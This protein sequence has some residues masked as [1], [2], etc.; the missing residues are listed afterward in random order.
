MGCSRPPPRNE[1][2][3][4]RLTFCFFAEDT[5]I[6]S[7]SG[8]FTEKVATMSAQDLIQHARGHQ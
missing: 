3:M 8:L 2:F 4:A 6:F 5:G 7:V 1:S